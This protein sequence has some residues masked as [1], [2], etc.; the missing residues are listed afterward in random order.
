MKLSQLGSLCSR[1]SAPQSTIHSGLISKFLPF[2]AASDAQ[3]GPGTNSTQHVNRTGVH[4]SA[5]LL[6]P[7]T[8]SARVVVQPVSRPPPISVKPVLPRAPTP[9][10]PLRRRPPL[11]RMPTTSKLMTTPLCLV[12]RSPFSL[13]STRPT[14]ILNISTPSAVANASASS[15]VVSTPRPTSVAKVFTPQLSTQTV[16][17]PIVSALPLSTVTVSTQPVSTVTMSNRTMTTSKVSTRP[18]PLPKTFTQLASIPSVSSSKAAKRPV[19]TSKYSIRP[20]TIPKIFTPL[21]SIAAESHTPVSTSAVSSAVFS[22]SPTVATTASTSATSTS[23]AATSRVTI[24]LV[25]TTVVASKP[26]NVCVS[27][28]SVSNIISSSVQNRR[29][30]IASSASQDEESNDNEKADLHLGALKMEESEYLYIPDKELPQEQGSSKSLEQ[31]LTSLLENERQYLDTLQRVIEARETLTSEL[32]DLLRGYD[33]LFNFHDDMYQNL[34]QEFPSSSGIAWVFLSHKEEL[35]QYRY[36]IMNAPKVASQLEQQTEEILKQHPTL[37][38][39]IKSSWKRIHFYFMTFEK[40]A[41]IVPVDEQDLVQKVV[42]LL[43]EIY[44]QGDSG[45]LID[46]VNGA[47]F[48]LHTLGTLVLH[49]LFTIKDPSGMLGN[50]TK[51]NVLLFEEMIVIVLPKKEKYQYKDHFP[52]RQLNLIAQSDSDKETFI[53]ELVQGGNK[54]NRKYTF[55]PRQP[56]AKAA[57]VTEISR[58]HLKYENEVERLRKLRSGYH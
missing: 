41:K 48:S 50:K 29:P 28:P 13:V 35:D 51:Y 8:P 18:L 38:L 39:D 1:P 58:L 25:S 36:C 15:P 45:I 3:R 54:K 26:V 42:D 7:D 46:A 53:L 57:W 44:R 55:R 12:S 21:A 52:L 33:I 9:V 22:S 37:E 2:T 11:V 24:T 19:F 17:T 56:E 30:S 32:Q 5:S 40:I 31:E 27:L 49:N 34:C 16:S 6:R 4:N 14:S 23:L 47:P 10:V 20:L 43:R